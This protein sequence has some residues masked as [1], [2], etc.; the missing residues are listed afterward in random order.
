MADIEVLLERILRILN[1]L[2]KT[3]SDI[4]EN[5][6]TAQGWTNDAMTSI[7]SVLVELPEQSDDED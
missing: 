7:R 2:H 3:L 1:D 5:I 6:I 4:Q